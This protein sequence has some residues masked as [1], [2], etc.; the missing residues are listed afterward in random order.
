M[1]P[2]HQREITNLVRNALSDMPVVV[3]T[4][5]RQVGKSTLLTKEPTLKKRRYF[6]LDDFAHLELARNNPES[7]I[8]GSEPV[9]IDE[10]QRCPELFLT[11]KKAVDRERKPGRF[12]LSGSAN[13]L[14][15][16]NV[17]ESLAGRAVYLTLHPFTRREI[18]Q[19][20]DMQPFLL[21]F[22]KSPGI[23]AND[24]N[25]IPVSDNEIF[26]GG[27]PTVTLESLKNPALWYKGYEQTY[28]QRDLRELSQVAD[29]LTFR[30]LMRL[31]ALR[32]GNILNNSEVA[33]DAHV[34][35][36]TALRY[37]NLLEISFIIH[38]LP[39]YLGNRAS[40]LI[41]SPKLFFSDSGLA[42]F[43]AGIED[44]NMLINKPF[45]GA[46]METYIAQ[47]LWS[48]LDA[49]C[50]T[51]NMC[52]WNVQGRHEVDFVIEKQ[53]DIFAFEVKA[54]SRWGKGDL[55]PL[56]IFLDRTPQ[57]KAAALVYN[58]TQLV[59]LGPKLWAIPT[60]LLLK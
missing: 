48:I 16:K 32:S 44:K 58:G 4:G 31:T 40:R 35:S 20:V 3:I 15:L 22:M 28:L 42:C 46:L 24:Y 17:S 59:Q 56:K 13:F 7:I 21:E 41:K 9:I 51:A 27:F 47:N 2:Y 52:F 18:A 25:I 30:Q 10:V 8:E 12:L 36:T 60:G 19:T 11:I 33:R 57:C 54:G 53:N 49:W 38:R 50:P 6:N 26:L 29:L 43:M 5:M 14:L 39:P 55:A 34:N 37:L 1:T 45:R 23:A